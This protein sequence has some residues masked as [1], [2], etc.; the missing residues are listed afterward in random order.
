M[1]RPTL[2]FIINQSRRLTPIDQRLLL[3]A[4]LDEL[5]GLSDDIYEAYT[6][7]MDALDEPITTLVLEDWSTSDE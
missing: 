5:M 2:N 3:S 7:T 4:V 6:E 1:I